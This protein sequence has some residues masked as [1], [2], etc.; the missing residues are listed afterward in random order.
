MQASIAINESARSKTFVT[1]FFIARLLS[2]GRII[3]ILLI[4]SN[5]LIILDSHEFIIKIQIC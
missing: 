1:V 3:Y 5:I 2:G 4:G